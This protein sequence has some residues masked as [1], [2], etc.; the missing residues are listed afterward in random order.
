MNPVA[1][2]DSRVVREHIERIRPLL[3][4][5]DAGGVLLFTPANILGFTGAPLG[6]TDR[7][8]CGLVSRDGA[9]ALVCPAFEAPSPRALPSATTVFT[10]L[11]DQNPYEAIVQAVRR[12]GL[13]RGTILLDPAVWIEVQRRLAQMMPSVTWREDDGAISAVRQVKSALEIE[14]IAG[15]CRRVGRIYAEIRKRLSPGVTELE[16]AGQAVFG[17]GN[18]SLS[19]ALPLTQSGPNA[20]IPHHPTSDRALSD[21]DCLVV[22]YVLAV[23]GYHGD[24]TRTFAVGRPGDKCRA[25]YRAVRAAQRAAIEAARPGATCESVDAAARAVIEKAGFGAYFV[26]RLGHS[27]GLDCHEA[28]FFVQGNR[29]KLL[30]GMCLTI[31]PGVYVP[32]EFGVRIEDVVAIT[33]SGCQILSDGV[34]TDVSEAFA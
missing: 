31:E 7:I 5:R 32:G 28:P 16:L 20:A 26:H 22:D 6:P 33:D 21:G 29:A 11:E 3:A 12:L 10:W 15:A 23:S 8:V 4:E 25:A 14:A 27:I 2:I 18:G 9:A 24:M 17:M 30:P 19:G 1:A 13:E 34:P